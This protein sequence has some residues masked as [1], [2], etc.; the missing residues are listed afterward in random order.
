M[1][2]NFPA[3]PCC[4][5]ASTSVVVLR[6]SRFSKPFA[7]PLVAFNA[8]DVRPINVGMGGFTEFVYEISSDST[9]HTFYVTPKPGS[10]PSMSW[11][12]P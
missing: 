9:G 6:S 11:T 12:T 5:C 3:F 8:Q 10:P 4:H 1:T 7:T 2:D